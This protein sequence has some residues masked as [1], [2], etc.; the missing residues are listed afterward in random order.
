[1]T[2]FVC[3]GTSLSFFTCVSL[4]ANDVEYLFMGFGAFHK[5][6]ILSLK[7]TESQVLST[8]PGLICT[9]GSP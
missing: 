3:T 2:V 9:E 4:V 1:M 8:L 6:I 5:L 7:E